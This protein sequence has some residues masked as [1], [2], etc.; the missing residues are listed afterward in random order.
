MIAYNLKDFQVEGVPDW[1]RS[2]D[3]IFDIEA[4]V[5]GDAVPTPS[6]VRPP[7][8]PTSAG[9]STPIRFTNRSMSDLA[10][11]LTSS[12]DRPVLDQT[13]LIATYDFTLSLSRFNPDLPSDDDRS[14][15]TA[16][17]QQLGLKLV[18]AKEPVPILVIEHA[19]RLTEN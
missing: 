5:E 18:P 3:Q 1:S 14:I 7:P 11:I 6:Q 12:V 2:R 13:G 9:P 8:P 19:E 17:Q 16:V 15:F 10:D 4:K